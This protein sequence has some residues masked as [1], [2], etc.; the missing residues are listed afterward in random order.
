MEYQWWIETELYRSEFHTCSLRGCFVTVGVRRMQNMR[1]VAE[2]V[3]EQKLAQRTHLSE[4]ERQAEFSR[5]GQRF[6]L[7]TFDQLVPETLLTQPVWQIAGSE[8]L[9]TL[10]E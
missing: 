2:R 3:L 7:I 9:G 6:C 4:A 1:A 10:F 5:L 8:R